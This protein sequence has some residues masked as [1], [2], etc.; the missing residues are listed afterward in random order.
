M[1]ISNTQKNVTKACE[2]IDLDLV[3]LEDINKILN[4]CVVYKMIVHRP[5]KFWTLELK[6]AVKLQNKARKAIGKA[7]RNKEDTR[8]PYEK[9]RKA[10]TK[11]RKL[12]QQAKRKYNIKQIQKAITDTTGAEFYRVIK[13]LEPQLNKKRRSNANNTAD[14]S[15]EIERIAETF[16]NIFCQHDVVPTELEK[17]KMQENLQYIHKRLAVEHKPDFTVRELDQAIRKANMRSAKGF[18]GVS[19]RLKF[20]YRC[21]YFTEH[22]CRQTTTTLSEK[23]DIPYIQ[24]STYCAPTKG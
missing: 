13:Q 8:G 11:F 4:E 9:Y 15:E 12:F 7:R 16:E 3:S 10:R 5:I 1:D 24:E 23:E 14:A 22:C 17:Q 20:A 6:K 2:G 19:S 21:P 18:D